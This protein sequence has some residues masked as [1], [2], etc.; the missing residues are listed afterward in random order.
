MRYDPPPGGKT[1]IRPAARIGQIHRLV[2]EHLRATRPTVRPD[3]LPLTASGFGA[4]EV[5]EAIDSLLA[6][7]TTM[8]PKVA[9]FEASWT[10]YQRSAASI[11]VNSGSSANLIAIATLLDPTG[12]RLLRTGDEVIVPAVTWS[13]TIF[14]L[15]QLGLVP[16]LVDVDPGTLNL[17][18]EGVEGALTRKTRALMPVHLLGN[19]CPM[20]EILALARK[21]GLA[22]VED[23]C[24]A[25]GAMVGKRRVGSFGELGTFSFF[26]SHHITTMEGGMITTRRRA[27]L[28]ILVSQRAHGWVRGRPDEKALRRRHAE[29]DPRFLFVT[30]GFNVRPT[31]LNAAFGLRQLPQLEAFIA[32]RRKNHRTWLQALA[33]FEDLF[34]FQEERPGTRH[35]AFGFSMVIRHGAPFSRSEMMR[36]L[37][38]RRVETRPIAGSNMARQPGLRLWPYRLGARRLPGADL[39]H[40]NGLFVG[41]HAGVTPAQRNHFVRVVR[42]F[43]ASHGAR[44]GARR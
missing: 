17:T 7:R 29:I 8:G 35:S 40:T 12:P 3:A 25:H 28:P 33:E 21:N 5:N 31:E 1:V 32:A 11:M 10:T 13:T 15:Q 2:E 23:C 41:N 37:E 6:L 22:V 44:P 24:E 20:N 39:V 38:A 14:P 26:F 4:A 9:R 36:Y 34:W 16:V 42:S 27:L 43:V 19:P 30:T 18:P